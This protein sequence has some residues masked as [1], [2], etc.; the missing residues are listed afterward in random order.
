MGLIYE[1]DEKANV[2]PPPS[3]KT[4][5]K[6]ITL[7]RIT[8]IP[9]VPSATADSDLDNVRVVAVAE[10]RVGQGIFRWV[11]LAKSLPGLPSVGCF[12]QAAITVWQG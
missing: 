9:M 6:G 7:R 3:P 2:P 10:C 1:R 12:W 11:D 8:G 5:M 4:G